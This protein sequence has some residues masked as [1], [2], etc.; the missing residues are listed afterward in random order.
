MTSFVA[1]RDRIRKQ[2]RKLGIDALLVTNPVNVRYLTGF[3][4][5]SGWLLLKSGSDCLLSDPRFTLQIEEE[6]PGLNTVINPR[7]IRKAKILQE[8]LVN[9]KGLSCTEKHKLGIES[10]SMTLSEKDLLFKDLPNC[11]AVLTKGV[12]ENFRAVKDRDEIKNIRKAVD[13][14]YTAF[15]VIQEYLRK[16]GGQ[17]ETETKVRNYLEL[18]MLEIGA[19][20]RSFNT[21]VG[22]GARAALPHGVPSGQKI[23]GQSH[24]LIDWGCCYRGYM[25]DLTRV[26]IFDKSDKQLRKI[27]ETVLKANE[28]AIEAIQPGKTCEEIDAVAT[29]ILKK[30]GLVKE[31]AHALGHSVGLEIHEDPRFAPG[32]KTVLEPGMVLTVEPGIYIAGFGGVRIEDDIVVTKTGCDVLSKDVPKQFDEMIVEI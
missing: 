17:I 3:T 24:L 2:F 22:A 19:E 21:I 31:A 1:R 7:H 13:I 32:F 25:S 11:E 9:R 6:C 18:M 5:S 10:A 4:G 23:T 14:A 26:L 27:Y 30:S 8:N 12:V 15:Q 20:D 16:K 28:A 29:K